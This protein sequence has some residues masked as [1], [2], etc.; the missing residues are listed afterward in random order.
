[1][2][3]LF[4][5]QIRFILGWDALKCLYF[6]ANLFRGLLIV[7]LRIPCHR[8]KSQCE[9]VIDNTARYNCATHMVAEDNSTIYATHLL[10]VDKSGM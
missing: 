10:N 9:E 6:T 2:T 5:I 4:R 1:M 8:L 7:I 3:A